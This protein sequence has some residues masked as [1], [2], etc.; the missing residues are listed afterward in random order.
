HPTSEFPGQDTV[1][2]FEGLK[3]SCAGDEGKLIDGML[4]WF[5]GKRNFYFWKTLSLLRPEMKIESV[6][7]EQL[8]A[9]AGNLEWQ[10]LDRRREAIEAIL[11]RS[12]LFQ[13]SNLDKPRIVK[14]KASIQAQQEWAE[15]EVNVK[16]D[17]VF[18]EKLRALWDR[19]GTGKAAI[20]NAGCSHQY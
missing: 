8:C 19:A 1:K 13:Q 9:R 5:D 7:D 3:A 11:E 4:R 15:Y 20:L 6:D 16:R 17:G 10:F 12:D 2:A 18:V 14:E